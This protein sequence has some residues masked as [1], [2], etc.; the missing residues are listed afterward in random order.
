MTITTPQLIS[1]WVTTIRCVII[2]MNW[3]RPSI[4]IKSI[5]FHHQKQL[6]LQVVMHSWLMVSLERGV[7]PEEIK[8]TWTQSNFLSIVIILYKITTRCRGIACLVLDSI[9]WRISLHQGTIISA[10]CQHMFKKLWIP[11]IIR[12]MILD[13][14]LWVFPQL[15]PQQ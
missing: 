4:Y 3:S 1:P 13:S 12:S 14:R 10:G 11:T 2:S 9:S 5:W 7:L 15:T 8:V 6:I